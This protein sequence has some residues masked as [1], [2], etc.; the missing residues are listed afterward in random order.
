MYRKFIA[1]VAAASIALTALG[2]ATPAAADE[3]RAARIAATILGLAVVGKIIH[4]KKKDREREREREVS[5]R[6]PDPVYE[7]YRPQVPRHDQRRLDPPRYHAP[8]APRPLPDRVDR[9]L[10]PQECLRSFD[11]R[12]GRVRVFGRRCL[13]E[14]YRFAHRL[15]DYCEVSFKTR[16]GRGR[17]YDARCLRDEGYRLARR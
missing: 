15:P 3:Y 9:R 6:A 4:D 8:V 11:T 7:S 16:E 5:R 14:N 17:G 13:E 2:A 12:E 1:T 10:L